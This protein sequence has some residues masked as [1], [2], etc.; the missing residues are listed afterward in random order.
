MRLGFYLLRIVFAAAVGFLTQ[1]S[2]D[3]VVRFMTDFHGFA[4]DGG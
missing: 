2:T 3:E 4:A 1:I